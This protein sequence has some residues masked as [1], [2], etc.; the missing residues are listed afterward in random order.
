MKN[1]QQNSNLEALRAQMSENVLTTENAIDVK[2]GV[3]GYTSGVK[4]RYKPRTTSG[5]FN[6]GNGTGI[7]GKPT[8]GYAVEGLL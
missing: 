5:G 8:T 4:S 7:N 1:A 2:G 6:V 3:G